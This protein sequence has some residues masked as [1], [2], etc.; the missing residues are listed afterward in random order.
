[1]FTKRKKITISVLA[2]FAIMANAFAKDSVELN[3]VEVVEKNQIIEELQSELVKVPGGTNLVN[4]DAITTSKSTLNDI[5]SIEPGIMMQEFFGANDQPRLNIRGS[6]IQSNPVNKGVNLLYDGTSINQA[7][8]SFVIGLIDPLQFSAVSVFRG[9][10]AMRYGS[11]S[12]GG[13]INFSPKT[14]LNSESFINLEAGSHNSKS[15]NLGL[16]GVNEDLDYYISAGFSESDGYRPMSDGERKNIGI[17]IGYQINDNIENRTFLNYTNN[18]FHIPMPL[19][20]QLSE[21]HPTAV[22]GDGY[23]EAGVYD[24]LMNVYKRKPHRDSEQFRV[25]NKTTFKTNDNA[26]YQVAVYAE[27]LDDEFANPFRHRTTEGNNFGINLYN[28]V[29]SPFFD[30]DSY[31]ISLNYN[32]GSM[33]TEYWQSDENDGSKLLKFA[34]L[35]QEAQNFS[36][37]VQYN[38]PI[39]NTLELVTDLQWITNTRSISG[40]A[41]VPN[42]AL[43]GSLDEKF[44][45]DALNPKIGLIYKMSRD[46]NIYANISKSMEAPTFD[47][48][49]Y[50]TAKPKNALSALSGALLVDLEEQTGTTYEIGTKGKWKDSS[51]QASYYYSKIKNELMSQ[52]DIS[53]VN[54]NTF[55]YTDK[56]THQGIELGFQQLLAKGIFD[57]SDKISTNIVYNYNNFKFDG[58]V[59]DGN[60]I[61]GI[62]K[63]TIYLELAYNL[64]DY[65]LISPNLK[66][67]PDDN[68]VDHVNSEDLKQDAFT[69]LGLKL[70]YQ[71]TPKLSFYADFKNLTD[72]TYN[73]SFAIRAES[74]AG[75]PTFLPG[76]GFN[77]SFG[78]KYT[79]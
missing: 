79:F 45:Y 19:Q 47:Q 50:E 60:Q 3:S 74:S 14:G 70:S 34:D 26:E 31:E 42:S 67:Q 46:S 25:S 11:A 58:G 41:S 78:M 27:K 38:L 10:N 21:D 33:P 39:N 55:N 76:D 57:S 22:M 2:S 23:E 7:D 72:E 63:Q 59:Y 62:P 35:E 40:D 61:A 66:I 12:L 30:N 44:T 53:A 16:G 49:V 32:Q 75:M 43:M 65:L 54:G 20:K 48:L 51:W 5:L 8:G 6:G 13:A 18:Y 56:T 24:A 37:N 68:Y 77:Y 28:K 71:S 36:I 52:V 9:S 69:L 1:M 15:V 17:N 4:L 73:S 64:G 29:T